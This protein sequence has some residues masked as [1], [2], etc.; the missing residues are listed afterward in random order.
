MK[1]KI[2]FIFGFILVFLFLLTLST[3]SFA[4]TYSNPDPVYNDISITT[5]DGFNYIG[6][7]NFSVLRNQHNYWCIVN[8]YNYTSNTSSDNR[9]VLLFSPNPFYFSQKSSSDRAIIFSDSMCNGNNFKYF[10]L[11][12]TKAKN[13]DYWAS[14]TS[15]L[16]GA[17]TEGAHFYFM[18]MR[19]PVVYLSNA[20]I[21]YSNSNEIFY[22]VKPNFEITVSTAEPTSNFI[23]AY[24]NYFSNNDFGKYEVYSSIDAV[25]WELM[26]YESLHENG[27]DLFRFYLKILN[28]GDYYFKFI[29]TETGE[30]NYISLTVTNIY[31]VT[32]QENINNYI[33]G[34]FRPTPFLTYDFIS[35]EEIFIYTQK[36]SGEEILKL[37]C[38]YST[39]MENWTR[40]EIQSIHDLQNNIDNYRFYFNCYEDGNYYVRFYNQITGEYTFS[41]IHVLFEEILKYEKSIGN[42]DN[43]S[44]NSKFSNLVQYFKDRFG[45]LTY[46]FE[47]IIDLFTRISKIE[48]NEEP[49]IHIPEL[50]D[51]FFNYKILDAT[52]FNFNDLIKENTIFKTIHNLY[53]MSVDVILIISFIALSKR[54]I[55]EVFGNG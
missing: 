30:E 44:D 15:G 45:F 49:I 51:P 11:N 43:N 4:H 39:D 31:H 52:D 53:L 19:N 21:Y 34:I 28:N 38:D 54:K 33:D 9:L 32:D 42:W 23:Y 55:E 47:F 12:A 2:L 27:K 35:D 25:N 24:S 8:Y 20:D 1:K 13:G 29:E 17:G 37:D 40:C 22:S 16:Y 48:V 26:Q 41:S 46:P 5:T 14:D 3:L 6:L 10:Y 7:P 50:R 18:D 36:F